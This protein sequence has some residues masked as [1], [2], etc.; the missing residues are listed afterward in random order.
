VFLSPNRYRLRTLATPVA[1][2]LLDRYCDRA[3]AAAAAGFQARAANDNLS[4]VRQSF[5]VIAK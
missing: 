1:L 5:V 3:S 2:V 4:K